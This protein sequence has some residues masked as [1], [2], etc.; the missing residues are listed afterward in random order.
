[1]KITRKQLRQLIKET[2]DT[3]SESSKEYTETLFPDIDLRSE[4]SRINK[5]L[6]ELEQ[7]IDLMGGAVVSYKNKIDDIEVEKDRGMR[8][9]AKRED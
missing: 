3:V 9:A 4:L 7:A 1:M 5:K 6:I 8:V 2:V